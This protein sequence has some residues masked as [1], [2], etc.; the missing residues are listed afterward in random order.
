MRGVAPRSGWRDENKGFWA[1][2]SRGCR[3][4]NAGPDPGW[5]YRHGLR[6]LPLIGY[7]AIF[8]RHQ[9]AIKA[10]Q[11]TRKRK[12]REDLPD[13]A[14]DLEACLCGF[15]AVPQNDSD[16]PNLAHYKNEGYEKWYHLR[17][18]ERGNVPEGWVLDDYLCKSNIGKSRQCHPGACGGQELM[19]QQRSFH[20]WGDPSNPLNGRERVP[21]QRVNL[22]RTRPVLALA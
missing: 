7:E 14:A 17:C 6:M 19:F 9:S 21:C 15:S 11:L 20:V 10:R 22:S 3:A 2:R 1:R 16:H 4:V 5:L 18:L 12:Q 8:C 13:L